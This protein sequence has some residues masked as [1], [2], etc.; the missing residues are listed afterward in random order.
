[1]PKATLPHFTFV[2]DYRPGIDDGSLADYCP[3]VD[4]G[5]RSE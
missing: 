1:M 5:P 4:R 2:F 3:G